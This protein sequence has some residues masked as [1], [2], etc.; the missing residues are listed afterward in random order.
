ML[1]TRLIAPSASAERL[2]ALIATR[3][4]PGADRDA[5]DARIWDLFGETWAVMFTDLTGFSRRV[6]EFGI[7]HFL[8]IIRE[9]LRLLIPI[10]EAHDG[11][12]LKVEGDSMMVIFRRPDRAMACAIAMRDAAAAYDAAVPATDRLGLC[13]GLGC[14]PMLRI[15]DQDVFGAE[16]NAASKLGEDT[17]K[18]GQ[19]VA[20]GAVKEACAEREGLRW[21]R[22]D[23]IPPGAGAAWLLEG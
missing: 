18:A 23:V 20:T 13:I 17:A 4:A 10:I 1:S 15:G 6:A 21:R 2:D 14:G 7:V 12:L 5:I 16:V 19:I 11:I 8:Q 3:L 9:S 22:L